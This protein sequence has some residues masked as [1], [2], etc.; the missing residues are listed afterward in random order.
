MTRSSCPCPWR[1]R[2]TLRLHQSQTDYCFSLDP[3]LPAAQAGPRG[4]QTRQHGV[5]ASPPLLRGQEKRTPPVV[6]WTGT[7]TCRCHPP[8]DHASRLWSRATSS[9]S[10]LRLRARCSLAQR[11]PRQ[12][13]TRRAYTHLSSRRELPTHAR[14]S[15]KTRYPSRRRVRRGSGG[16]RRFFRA[17]HPRV[18]ATWRRITQT[19][20][21]PAPTEESFRLGFLFRRTFATA[22]FRESCD[23]FS[24]RE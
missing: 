16:I 20:C 1:F 17:F 11:S 3:P 22:T 23:H 19:A 4:S 7:R 21:A 18:R 12:S 10:P 9:S 2:L 8:R 14:T 5:F 15:R 13:Q 24:S 6:V